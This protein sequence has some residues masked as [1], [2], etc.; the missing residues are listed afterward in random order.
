MTVNDLA[1]GL[2][3]KQQ[4]DAI[5]LD[6]SKAFDK[7]PH[8]R[9]L[10]RLQQYGVRGPNLLKWVE[11]FLSTRTQEVV[12][13]GTKS[14][15]LQV[16]SVVPQGTVLGPLLFLAYINDMS[17]G[18]RSTVKLFVDDSLLYRKISNKRDCV[19]LQQDL[20][21]L[22]ELEKKWQMSFKAEKMRSSV[23]YK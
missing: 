1:R 8:Q 12:I 18:I 15:P 14:T 5:L 13:D 22:Q 9:L 2:N 16:S 6:F 10:L 20:V 7:V 4:V 21:R 11:D 3:K 17:E 19:E 23:H